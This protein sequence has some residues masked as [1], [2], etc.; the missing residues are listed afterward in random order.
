MPFCCRTNGKRRPARWINYYLL[1]LYLMRAAAMAPRR[2]K[3]NRL[4]V[5]YRNRQKVFIFM[6][7]IIWNH[8]K[9]VPHIEMH[10]STF[11]QMHS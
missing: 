3:T 5:P 9:F 11:G 10:Y 2:T 7:V 4:T 1:I 8:E 6:L